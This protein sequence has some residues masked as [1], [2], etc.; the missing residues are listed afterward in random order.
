[1]PHDVTADFS[2]HPRLH[3]LLTRIYGDTI[4][5][6]SA[7]PEP[8]PERF[9]AKGV[10]PEQT[11]YFLDLDCYTQEQHAALVNALQE[12]GK[13]LKQAQAT[14]KASVPLPVVSVTV[15]GMVVFELEEMS[16][17]DMEFLREAVAQNRRFLGLPPQEYE[18]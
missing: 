12:D 17:D 13:T 15:R 2:H 18:N 1:M 7:Y 4:Y 6:K 3:E 5:L 9:E 10:S 8:L 16:D 11:W 14:L